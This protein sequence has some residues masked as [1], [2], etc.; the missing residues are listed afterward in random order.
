MNAVETGS[1]WKKKN[2][3]TMKLTCDCGNACREPGQPQLFAKDKYGKIIY[4]EPPG[5]PGYGY[6]GYGASG[7]GVNPY[8]TGPYGDPNSRFIRP[9]YPYNRPYGPYSGGGY[10]LPVAGG[11][12]AGRCWAGY[13]SKPCSTLN[14]G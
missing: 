10:G 3:N 13:C 2:G 14:R 4:I 6:G 11:L 8:A 1:R 9:G 5:G 12:L 7:Y